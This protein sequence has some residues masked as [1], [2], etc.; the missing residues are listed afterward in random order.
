MVKKLSKKISVEVYTN[1]DLKLFNNFGSDFPYFYI[2][3]DEREELKKLLN[4]PLP[5]EENK[6]KD[7]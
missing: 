7:L 5:K 3:S 6:L 2:F 4:E 1:G